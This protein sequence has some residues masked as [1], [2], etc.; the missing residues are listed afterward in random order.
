MKIYA[1]LLLLISPAF[2]FAPQAFTPKCTSLNLYEA[3]QAGSTWFGTGRGHFRY[4][5][6][7]TN[8]EGAY[9]NGLHGHYYDKL[10]DPYPT[11]EPRFHP[12]SG[13]VGPY[14]ECGMTGAYDE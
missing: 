9:P 7:S 6:G 11:M 1:A 12:A 3:S 14:E 5:S 8:F 4:G 13:F 10:P 2:A